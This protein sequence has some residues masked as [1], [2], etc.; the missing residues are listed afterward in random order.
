M[1]LLTTYNSILEVESKWKYYERMQ[2][3]VDLFSNQQS[4]KEFIKNYF[5]TGGKGAIFETPLNLDKI[6][7]FHT[8]STFFLGIHLGELILENATPEELKPDFMYL[9]YL[10]SLYHDFGYAVE[11]NNNDYPLN[12]YNTLK[13]LKSR[14]SIK[15]DVLGLHHQQMI[16]NNETVEAYHKYCVDKRGFINHGLV[17]GLLLYDR[18]K[19]NLE[20]RKRDY[21]PANWQNITGEFVFD[22]L[23]WGDHQLDYFAKVAL[24]IINH[25][26]WFCINNYKG[27][28]KAY[29]DFSL[30]H[31]IMDPKGSLKYQRKDNPLFY[32]L[33]L[34][35][36]IEPTKFFTN[37]KPTCVLEKVEISVNKSSKQI[38]IIVLEDCLEFD[39]WFNKIEDLQ[40]WMNLK[41]KRNND[42][43]QLIIQLNDQ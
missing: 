33:A 9:W 18:L 36:T 37:L 41:I 5:G 6:R 32:L 20:E 42:H 22:D 8:V 1:S 19:K 35:D 39:A 7:V 29:K 12:D 25:N 43:R 23:I 3:P 21:S 11:T 4:A 28:N 40:T 27:C 38:K 30:R 24:N 16:F 14:L 31:L 34:T 26:I 2:N 15:N 13:K 17:G 10:T